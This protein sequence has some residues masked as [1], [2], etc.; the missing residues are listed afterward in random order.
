MTQFVNSGN[1]IQTR[2]VQSA[3]AQ[4]HKNQPVLHNE[5]STIV[6][7]QPQG[8]HVVSQEERIEYRDQ[9][10]NILNEEQVISLQKEGKVSFQTRYETRT[11]LINAGGRE[12]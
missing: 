11:R 12:L 5:Q 3:P 1:T 6:T 8:H 7:P 9:D 4:P 10:G 2:P